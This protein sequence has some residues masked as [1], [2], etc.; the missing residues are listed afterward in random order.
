[1]A[2]LIIH[3]DA[4]ARIDALPAP[5]VTL[6][7]IEAAVTHR[8]YLVHGTLTI[9]IATLA[10]GFKVVGTSACASPEN[11]DQAVG[12]RL[13]FEDCKRQLW[14]LLGYALRDRLHHLERQRLDG[15]GGGAG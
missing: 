5:K 11:F 2:D 10:N 4:E 12:E 1:M 8:S 3:Q 6:A 14:P 9:C 7:E 13:A 15:R